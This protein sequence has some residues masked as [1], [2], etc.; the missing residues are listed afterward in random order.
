MSVTLTPD[1]P[2]TH[3]QHEIDDRV[4]FHED[5][6]ILEIDL[7]DYTLENS[8][9]VNL[10][11]DRLETLIAESG[12]S[13]WFFLINYR[14]T[15][16]DPG[17]W[18]A[19]AR[20][21]K[22]LNLAHSMGSVRYDASEDTRRQIE[23]SA[24]TDNFDPNLFADRESAYERLK[25]MPSTRVHKIVHVPN[26]SA[27]EFRRRVTFNEADDIMEIDL[28]DIALEHSRDVHDLYDVLDAMI[29]ETGRKWY[30]LINYENTKI[31]S[32][33]WVEY[34]ARGKAFNEAGSLGSVRFAPGSET[35]TDIR[36]R[37]ESGGFRPNI[38][39]T[40]EEAL[41]RIAELKRGED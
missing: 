9:D 17:A 27:E 12:E 34:A 19:H 8:A 25:A 1:A 39:N 33:A 6:Q 41:E 36:L 11:Y 5:D 21:G 15:K 22:D 7:S 20:R 16:I 13:Q 32:C 10:L 18:F 37:A 38:R 2:A 14:G 31:F 40:R 29:A 26:H 3:S 28:T 23:R 30:F 35:E 4:V 24:G